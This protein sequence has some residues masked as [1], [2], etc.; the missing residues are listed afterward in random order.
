MLKYFDKIA[1]GK[2]TM[3]T[4]LSKIL[5]PS[6]IALTSLSAN[7]AER[8]TKKPVPVPANNPMTADKIALGKLLYFDTRLSSTNKVSCA[9]CHHA[10]MGWASNDPFAVG[11]EGREGPRNSPT[12]LNNAYNHK[13]FWDGRANSLEEQSL[14]PIQAGVEM[15]MK[16]EDVISMLKSKKEYVSLFEKAFPGEGVTTTTLAKAIGSF[17]RT[18]VSNADSKFDRFIAGDTKAMSKAAQKGFELFK[19]K[20]GC[21][22]CHDNFQFTDG[23]FHNISLGDADIGRY[24]LKKRAAWYHAFKTPTLRD[25]TKSAPYFHDGSVKTLEEATTICASGGRYA[26]GHKSKGKSPMMI[27][28]HLTQTEIA[29]IV[30]F[31]KA[32]EGKPLNITQPTQFPQ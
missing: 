5:L 19:A 2:S 23:S 14:G 13:Y 1:L 7:N 3:N 24:K 6:I 4:L 29:Q 26:T 8:W 15:N 10:S 32:L 9:S 22:V 11:I 30:S 17:E 18:I 31:M 16:L 27:D 25:V 21:A 12:V 28:R 20:A